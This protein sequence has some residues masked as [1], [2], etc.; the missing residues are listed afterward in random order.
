M[1]DL[2]PP[3]QEPPPQDPGPQPP[4]YGAQPPPEP[5]GVYPPYGAQSNPYHPYGV[6]Y[7]A[8]QWAPDHPQAT[9]VLILGILGIT[10]CQVIAPFAWVKGSRVRG[11][12]DAAGGRYGGRSQAQ[13]GYV[14]GIVGS[15]LLGLYVVGFLFYIAVVVIAVASG[16]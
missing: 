6:G 7:G 5:P 15:V 12:I 10:L 16:A 9:T 13:I 4:S 14:L 2:P 8:P 3:G 11:E 1:T